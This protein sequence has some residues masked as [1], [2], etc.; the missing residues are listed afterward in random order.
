VIAH[1]DDPLGHM[2]LTSHGYKGMIER[3]NEVSPK[4]I[5]LGTG[6]YKYL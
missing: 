1:K 3:I 5:D 2:N 4:I 6:G